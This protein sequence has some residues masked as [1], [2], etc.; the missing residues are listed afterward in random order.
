MSPV[1]SKID[2]A[3]ERTLRVSAGKGEPLDLTIDA[4][5]PVAVRLEIENNCGC[6]DSPVRG[7][8]SYTDTDFGGR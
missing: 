4:S 7:V 5:N 1:S 2:S 3:K 8:G 6:A